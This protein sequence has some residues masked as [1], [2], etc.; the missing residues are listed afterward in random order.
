MRPVCLSGAARQ[1]DIWE[2]DADPDVMVEGQSGQVFGIAP[3]P[4]PQKP[5]VYASGC[6]VR[7]NQGPGQR[8][9][10]T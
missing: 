4:D 9:E 8:L 7:L 1:N 5:Y 6:E 10:L 3:Y 2:V